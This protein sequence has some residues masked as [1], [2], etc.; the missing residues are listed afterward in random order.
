MVTGEKM[1]KSDIYDQEIAPHMEAIIKICEDNKI[2]H[3]FSICLGE[4]WNITTSR[5]DESDTP[6]VYKEALEILW[7]TQ[8]PKDLVDFFSPDSILGNFAT[9][10]DENQ[11][12]LR[13]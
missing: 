6:E 12:G 2:D 1:K 11:L 9:L 10:S 7:P 4:D 13:E 5:I 8:P 3:L